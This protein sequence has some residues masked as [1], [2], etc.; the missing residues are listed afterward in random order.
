MEKI[1]FL[2]PVIDLKATGSRIKEIRKDKGFTVKDI[3][4][5]F[6]FEFPQAVYA[7]EQGKNVPTIDNLIVLGRIFNVSI[8]ELIATKIVEI[9]VVC[10]ESTANKICNKKCDTCKWKMSA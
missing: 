6:G 1:K 8:E 4:D 7:W 5:I 2:K 3:Q 10:S 9:D